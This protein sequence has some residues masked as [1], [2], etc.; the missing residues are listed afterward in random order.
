MKSERDFYV[1]DYIFCNFTSIK[2]HSW[3]EQSGKADKI[4]HLMVHFFHM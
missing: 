4:Y 1:V 2:L 3:V